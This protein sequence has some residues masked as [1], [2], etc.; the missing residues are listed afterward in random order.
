MPEKYSAGP[1]RPA[2]LAVSIL[3][4]TGLLASASGLASCARKPR[5]E[6][7]RPGAAL[8]PS[9]PEPSR[10]LLD[11]SAPPKPSAPLA[12]SMRAF[13][14]GAPSVPR[15]PMDFSL[16]PLQS[17]SP[18]S[19]DESAAFAVARSFMDSLAAGKLDKELLF[20]EAREALSILLAPAPP[21]PAPEGAA[22]ESAA[23]AQAD[24]SPYRLGA[25]SIKGEDASLKVRLP[26][27]GAVREEGLLSLRKAG[28]RWYIE[29]LA[30]DPPASGAPAFA[31]DAFE[32]TR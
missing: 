18:A 17:Y 16:G 3:A 8:A 2:F 21:R 29:A 13:G 27:A 20:P 1:R 24:A 14:L 30:L 6:L 9:R 26:S 11:A 23:K 19:G 15:M 28:D 12:A 32:R 10:P 5:V 22:E 31:P 25:I 7:P 4:A